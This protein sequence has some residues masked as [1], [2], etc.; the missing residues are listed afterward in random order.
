ML[1][2]WIKRK[3]HFTCWITTHPFFLA[4]SLKDL[5]FTE[6]AQHYLACESWLKLQPMMAWCRSYM[7]FSSHNLKYPHV[8]HSIFSCSIQKYQ[9]SHLLLSFVFISRQDLDIGFRKP[10]PSSMHLSKPPVFLLLQ[11]SNYI[12]FRKVQV[13]IF[14]CSPGAKCLCF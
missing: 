13:V 10:S 14:F 11:H 5:T 1:R 6:Q 4:P 3:R 8:F 2:Y 12:V 7:L 9:Q